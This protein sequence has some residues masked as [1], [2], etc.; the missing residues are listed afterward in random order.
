MLTVASYNIHRCYGRDGCYKPERTRAVLSELNAHIVAL[1]EVEVLHSALGLLDYFCHHS[2]YS[3]IPGITM[4]RPSSDYGNALLTSLPVCGVERV[5]FTFDGAEPR[6][7][8]S[9]HLEYGE[10]KV[11]VVATHLGLKKKERLE[12]IQQL[13]ALYEQTDSDN[14]IKI[15]M[16]DLNEWFPWS[17]NNRMLAEYF[18]QR[19]SVA[20]F[21]SIMPVLSLDRI[22]VKPGKCLSALFVRQ[23]RTATIASDHLPLL[24]TIKC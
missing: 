22:Y 14:V 18:Q 21:P 17:H 7:A 20:T 13:L 19:Q 5:D 1:Q 16:G 23:T 8:L 3:A 24:A 6:G 9:V 10:Y 12:Q 15:L 11:H 2:R 4:M